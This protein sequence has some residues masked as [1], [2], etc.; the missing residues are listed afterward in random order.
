MSKQDR[1]GAR[2]PAQL[3]QRYRFGQTFAEA[4][5]LSKE[6]LETAEKAKQTAEGAVDE[7]TDAA[8]KKAEEEVAQ[9][10]Q[11]LTQTDI[12]NRLTNHGA[13]KGL[14]MKDGELYINADF[15]AT[16]V[17]RSADGTVQLDLGNNTVTINGTRDG[18]KTQIVLSS[19]GLSAYGESSTGIM[20]H[21]LDFAFGVGGKPTAITNNA[22]N[23]SMGM[24]IAAATGILG[25]GTSEAVT[26]I[27]GSDV[28]IAPIGDLKLLGKT[29]SWKANSDGTYT[30]VGTG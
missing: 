24:L 7:A 30:L 8:Q 3:E 22:W 20:E 29:A 9:L 2:T 23:E 18:Y 1:Q 4:M 19:S 10:D 28:K 25:L 15:L 13:A 26:E 12:F 11:K 5:G 16:G 14:F 17:L 27:F 21:V 6:A